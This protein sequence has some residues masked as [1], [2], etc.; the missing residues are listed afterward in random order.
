MTDRER[1]SLVMVAVALVAIGLTWWNSA[2]A[3]TPWTL[4]WRWNDAYIEAFN[5]DPI[6]GCIDASSPRSG[7]VTEYEGK[8]RIND[9]WSSDAGWTVLTVGGFR[10]EN[11][12]TAVWYPLDSIKAQDDTSLGIDCVNGTVKVPFGGITTEEYKH[13]YQPNT[14]A[15]YIWTIAPDGTWYGPFPFGTY[16]PN[17]IGQWF[18]CYTE[19]VGPFEYLAK[20]STTTTTMPPPTPMKVATPKVQRWVPHWGNRM[21]YAI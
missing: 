3:A 11:P 19:D 8:V 18:V 10:I 17:G 2:S 14:P 15:G 13:I 6:E 5:P 1:V 16:G 21:V 4:C 12:Q 7:L 9:Y 20:P